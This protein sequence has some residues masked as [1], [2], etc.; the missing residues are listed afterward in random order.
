MR[1]TL[2][3]ASNQNFISNSVIKFEV[4]FVVLLWLWPQVKLETKSKELNIIRPHSYFLLSTS[5]PPSWRQEAP[6][7]P[8]SLR[9]LCIFGLCGSSTQLHLN[10]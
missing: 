1:K 2:L 9:L 3:A 5:K 6:R 4:P 8:A 7:A 10:I